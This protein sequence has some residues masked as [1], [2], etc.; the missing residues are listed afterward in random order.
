[1]DIGKPEEQ[2]M[3]EILPAKTPVPEREKVPA[4][5]PAEDD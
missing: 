4:G 5:P 1:M 3:I 2:P